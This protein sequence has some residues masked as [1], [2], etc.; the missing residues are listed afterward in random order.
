MKNKNDW[1]IFL[2]LILIQIGFLVTLSQLIA[3]KAELLVNAK[4]KLKAFEQKE[5]NMLQLQQDYT[6]IEGEAMVL[7]KVL[8]NKEETFNFI[9]QLENEASSSGILVKINFASNS[10]RQGAGAKEVALNLD[11]QGSYF[12]MLEL[13]EKIEKMP[14][15]I[16]IDRIVMQSP[17]GLAQK[18]NHLV[19]SLTLFVDPNF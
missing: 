4:H 16:R 6:Q 17:T 10:L 12:D 9:S 19:L 14:Q 1:L 2:V 11:F 5:S 7:N 8:P 13:L 3:Q 18:Q 15:V